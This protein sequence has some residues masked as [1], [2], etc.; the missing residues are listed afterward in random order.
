[1]REVSRRIAST[2]ASC[3]P[4]S[5]GGFHATQESVAAVQRSWRRLQEVASMLGVDR[6]LIPETPEGVEDDDASSVC[7]CSFCLQHITTQPTHW[8]GKEW[9]LECKNFYSY[10]HPSTKH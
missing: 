2:I 8:Q 7:L 6:F 3:P 4:N 9:H 5:D 1:M 10:T